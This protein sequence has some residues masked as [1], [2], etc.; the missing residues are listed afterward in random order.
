MHLPSNLH[1]QPSLAPPNMN[2]SS[3]TAEQEAALKHVLSILYHDS[4][5]PL[6]LCLQQY[7]CL[8]V[9][10]LATL[11]THEINTLT[12]TP[13]TKTQDGFSLTPI[14]IDLP[15]GFKNAIH[16]FQGYVTYR[17][18]IGEPLDDWLSIT[19]Q[20]ID[21]YRY[22]NNCQR[23]IATLY[24]PSKTTYPPNII[25]H[26]HHLQHATEP[27]KQHICL[28][29]SSLPPVVNTGEPQL[30]ATNM[31]F[32]SPC[33]E[34]DQTVI[35]N[36][37]LRHSPKQSKSSDTC[38]PNQLNHDFSDKGFETNNVCSNLPCGEDNQTM[39]SS[40]TLNHNLQ[41]SKFSST[42][43]DDKHTLFT[44]STTSSNANTLGVPKPDILQPTIQPILPATCQIIPVTHLPLPLSKVFNGVVTTC[45]NACCLNDIQSLPR[46]FRLENIQE[47]MNP[48]DSY[49]LNGILQPHDNIKH[50]HEHKIKSEYFPSIEPEP[51]PYTTHQSLHSINC[52]NLHGVH[53]PVSYTA[54]TSYGE[55]KFISFIP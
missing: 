11:P 22:S 35:P 17:H 28:P 20:D 44:N 1:M 14:M 55:Y 31:F 8:N 53:P 27:Y 33:G 9:E 36:A 42:I 25:Q 49:F 2:I 52:C 23:Y 39:I 21:Q 10:D 7:P 24:N 50:D 48:I 16:S 40:T 15:K 45:M 51:P 43:K 37:T 34:E 12:Y 18:D 30:Q 38:F 41:Q 6:T 29:D 13:S 19:Q 26:K 54:A 5:S 32:N 3:N 46:P 4:D 47:I